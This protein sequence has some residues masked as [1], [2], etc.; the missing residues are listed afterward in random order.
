MSRKE[1]VL[2]CFDGVDESR[3]VLII[4]LV[5]DMIFIEEQL[6]ELR[7]LPLIKIHPKNPEMQKA[8]S[9]GKLYKEYLQQY[10]NIVRSL[11]SILHKEESGEGDSPLREYFKRIGK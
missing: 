3:R 9:A 6:D 10:N 7:K 2:K 8:T 5:D 4:K 1:E 11:C